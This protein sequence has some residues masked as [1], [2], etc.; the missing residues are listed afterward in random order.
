[1]GGNEYSRDE[2][3]NV[4]QERYVSRRGEANVILQRHRRMITFSGT[5]IHGS[6]TTQKTGHKCHIRETF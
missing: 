5:T 1:M 2:K 3:R 6:E 4:G